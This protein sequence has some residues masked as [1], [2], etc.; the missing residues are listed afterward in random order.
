MSQ[1]GEAILSPEFTYHLFIHS[2][3]PLLT[4]LFNKYFFSLKYS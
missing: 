3:I 4:H 2:F 1:Y